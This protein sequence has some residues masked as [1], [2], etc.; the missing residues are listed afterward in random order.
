MQLASI[1]LA[2]GL[3]VASGWLSRGSALMQPYPTA[4]ATIWTWPTGTAGGS[5]LRVSATEI[6]QADELVQS[7]RS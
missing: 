7:D 5:M 4:F 3:R 2:P 6:N 1:R